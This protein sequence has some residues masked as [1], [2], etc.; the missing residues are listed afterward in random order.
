MLALKKVAVTGGLAS[1]KTE[2]CRLFEKC[3][4]YVVSADAIVHRLLSPKTSV[5]QRV[6]A[7]FGDDICEADEISREKLALQ[8]FNSREKLALLEGLLHPAVAAGIEE[9]YKRAVAAK[10]LL[11]VAEVPLLFETGMDKAFDVLISV[12]TPLEIRK[13]R[14]KG[15]DFDKRVARQ[16]SDEERS[17]GAHYII[18]NAG[19]RAQLEQQVTAIFTTMLKDR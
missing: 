16:T 13:G 3:G 6:I 11:F 14:Y 19:D 15:A 1:G 5:S 18:N 12:I 4:A 17:K 10:A 2:V 8:V 7:L 9:A